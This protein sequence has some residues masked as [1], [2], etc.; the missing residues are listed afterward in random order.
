MTFIHDCESC[1]RIIK[2]DFDEADSSPLFCPFCGEDIN[3]GGELTYD[4]DYD[5][6]LDTAWSDDDNSFHSL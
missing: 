4:G 1:N 6:E 3:E 5:R 2:L